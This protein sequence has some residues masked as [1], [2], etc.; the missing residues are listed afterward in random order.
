MARK[1]LILLLIL[2]VAL[3]FAFSCE[4][5]TPTHVVRFMVDGELFREMEVPEG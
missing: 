4:I 1:N 5:H 3:L 2:S